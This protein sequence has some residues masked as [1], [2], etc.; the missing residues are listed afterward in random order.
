MFRR[1]DT[2]R[3]GSE[4]YRLDWDVL[5]FPKLY[6]FL[7]ITQT[8]RKILLNG[9]TSVAQVVAQ[10]KKIKHPTN[11]TAG[12]VLKTMVAGEGVEPPTQGFSAIKS[13]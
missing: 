3:K 5:Q 11:E 13:S 10:N 7:L 6:S 8:K 9:C 2:A 1:G 4:V 12:R